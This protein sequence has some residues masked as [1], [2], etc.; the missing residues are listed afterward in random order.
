MRTRQ[1]H[2]PAR[3]RQDCNASQRNIGST[4]AASTPGQQ[5]L[6]QKCNNTTTNSTKT[7]KDQHHWTSA[8]RLGKGKENQRKGTNEKVELKE[9]KGRALAT[10][11]SQEKEN[12]TIPST[13]AIPSRDQSAKESHQGT[14]KEKA[15]ERKH[16]TNIANRVTRNFRVPA[17]N[18]GRQSHHT[19]QPMIGTTA[20]I[21]VMQIGTTRTSPNKVSQPSPSTGITSAAASSRGRDSTSHQ[22]HEQHQ[23]WG[24]GVYQ[25]HWTTININRL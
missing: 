3:Q 25:C 7:T 4:L 21:S 12:I 23:N 16:A 15:K 18:R 1:Q 20:H 22:R 14:S 17:R 6:S 2:H 13:R 19:D 8:Q 10:T 9:I 11:T 24:R 5:S